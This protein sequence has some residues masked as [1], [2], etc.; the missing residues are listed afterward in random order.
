[1]IAPVQLSVYNAAI[2]ATLGAAVAADLQ[3]FPDAPP[4][5]VPTNVGA[6]VSPP[7]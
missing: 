2:D 1:M 4:G 7:V 5:M 3:R 6:W